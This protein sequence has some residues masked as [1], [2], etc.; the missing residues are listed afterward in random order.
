MGKLREFFRP[1]FLNRLDDVVLFKPLTHQDIRSIVDLLVADVRR[2]LGEQGFGLEL[3]EAASDLIVNEGYDPVYGAR[4][5]KRFI[6]QQLETPIARAIVG[7]KVPEGG[8]VR[9]DAE[10]GRLRV[11]T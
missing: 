11:Q 3:T 8:Q 4:P 1:E 10:S 5:L 2:R 6:Q 9:V 7:G